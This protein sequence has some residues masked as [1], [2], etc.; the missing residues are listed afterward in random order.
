MCQ[1]LKDR[2]AIIT[3]GAGYLGSHHARRLAQEG[4]RV[5]IAD[6]TDG[7]PLADQ[8]SAG[9]GEAFFAELDVT[10]WES[11]HR[12]VE[13]VLDR[14]GRIDILINNAGL[15]VGMHKPWTEFDPADWDRKMNIDL[16]GSF[17]CAR[18]VFPTMQHQNGG[19]II[20]IASQVVVSAP[21]NFLPHVSV[22]AGVVGFTR[23]LATE[24]GVYNINVNAILVGGFLQD[25][26]RVERV[27]QSQALKRVPNPE[28]LSS[29]VV[30]LSSDD[31][32]WITGQALA[33]CG[34]AIRT[35]G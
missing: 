28:D 5:V 32:R 8:I 34:G 14:W 6:L 24:V 20:N 23:A 18:A 9:G 2:V 30:F 27:I 7:K 4:A 13:Q 33:V 31:A 35:G 10:N 22:K 21:A 17:I 19:K 29:V 11:A 3:G 25:P 1:R 16:K 15:T 26:A 12:L